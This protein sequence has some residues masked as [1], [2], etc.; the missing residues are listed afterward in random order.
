MNEKS[1]G[2]RIRVITDEAK[3]RRHQ[4]RKLMRL[5]VRALIWG[6]CLVIG[7]ALFLL[8]LDKMQPNGQE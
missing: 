6:L 5:V 4:R 1:R 7:A 3:Y 8:L 2:R